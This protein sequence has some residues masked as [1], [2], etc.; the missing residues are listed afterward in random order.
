[1]TLTLSCRKNDFTTARRE[2]EN[3]LT[4]M[5]YRIYNNTLFYKNG[6]E[7][8]SEIDQEFQLIHRT[9]GELVDGIVIGQQVRIL[10]SDNDGTWMIQCC[11]GL[12]EQTKN[13]AWMIG[14]GACLAM[15]D[16]QLEIVKGDLGASA[17]SYSQ[18]GRLLL[19]GITTLDNVFTVGNYCVVA[20]KQVSYIITVLDEIDV[21]WCNGRISQDGCLDLPGIL[22]FNVDDEKYILQGSSI[23]QINGRLVP[24]YRLYHSDTWVTICRSRAY[25]PDGS[26]LL[27]LNADAAAHVTAIFDSSSE[28]VEL[29]VLDQLMIIEVSEDAPTRSIFQR[30][31]IYFKKG[32]YL[33]GWSGL[34]YSEGQSLMMVLYDQIVDWIPVTGRR[35]KR[36][37]TVDPVVVMT[38]VYD[39]AMDA[40]NLII[41]DDTGH[42][43]RYTKSLVLLDVDNC[44]V[45]KSVNRG[46]VM[47]R[48]CLK[49]ETYIYYDVDPYLS[50]MAVVISNKSNKRLNVQFAA[51]AGSGATRDLAT[52]FC[53]ELRDKYM[54]GTGLCQFTKL[55]NAFLTGLAL[56]KCW[57][58]VECLPIHLPFSVLC[59]IKGS[60]PS[61]KQRE[62]LIAV[63]DKD[64]HANLLKIKADPAQARYASYEDALEEAMPSTGPYDKEVLSGFTYRTIDT[65]R[66]HNIATID[67]LLSGEYSIDR[68]LLLSKITWLAATVPQQQVITDLLMCTTEEALSTLLRNWTGCSTVTDGPKYSIVV[69]S[70]ELSVTLHGQLVHE[71]SRS[72]ISPAEHIKGYK[73]AHSVRFGVCEGSM[74]I[75][76]TLLERPALLSWALFS[77]A[78][79]MVDR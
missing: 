14:R 51:S 31:H 45:N 35:K 61:V 76:S 19:P 5:T 54:T 15:V 66:T 4:R 10:I 68:A 1:M 55:P 12:K 53:L 3:L 62:Q 64:V 59:A 21:A 70:I 9:E 16:D 20:S 34:F 65:L 22:S 63:R 49:T 26:R 27:A 44:R 2:E 17:K 25:L 69:E 50:M 36:R 79:S 43:H 41:Q 57:V 75:E 40:W 60:V 29:G 39:V 56:K 30:R 7:I 24:V 28:N 6:T 67:Y 73:L 11:N 23:K 72:G 77:P 58:A 32:K 71:A 33:P 48:L 37:K 78:L 13:V 18:G 8:H 46:I 52:R 47:P 74:R 42:L 38:N